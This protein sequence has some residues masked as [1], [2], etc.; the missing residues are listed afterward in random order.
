MDLLVLALLQL[1]YGLVLKSN[2]YLY[3]WYLRRNVERVAGP[4]ITVQHLDSTAPMKRRYGGEPLA[5]LSP[6]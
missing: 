3:S 5:M 4:I 1:I 2:L 6:N